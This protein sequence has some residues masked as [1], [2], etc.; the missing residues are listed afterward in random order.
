M[1]SCE[2][3]GKK[4]SSPYTLS[5]HHKRQPVCK[6]WLELEPGLKDFVNHKV[7]VARSACSTEH[8]TT[9]LACNTTFANVGNLNRHLATSIVCAKWDLYND[10]EPVQGYIGKYYSEFEFDAPK[11]SVC[12]IIWNVYLIDK[13]LAKS[14]AAVSSV[15]KENKIKYMIAIL[16]SQDDHDWLKN[17]ADDNDLAH[18]VMTYDDHAPALDV[19]EFRRQCDVIEEYR[20]KR[21]NVIVFCNNGYQRSIPFLTYYLYEHHKDEV[22]SIDRAIDI[23]LP[24]VDKAQYSKLRDEYI[25][26]MSKLFRPEK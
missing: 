16:P 7:Q 21:Q 20:R 17:L 23:I 11:Y 12:H 14:A 10:L 19:E 15:V 18:H 2:A 22:P 9:C 13:E 5:K 6:R 1:N 8:N 3:C 4:Y 24:Q 25:D 26:S